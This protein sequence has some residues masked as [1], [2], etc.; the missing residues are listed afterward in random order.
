[1]IPIVFINCRKHPFLRKIMDLSKLYETRTRN[2]LGK[3]IGQR[4]LLCET[5]TGMNL[6]RCSAVIESIVSVRSRKD[7]EVY[8]EAACIPAGSDYDW[9]TDTKVKWLYKLTDVQPVQIPFTPPEDVRHGR[10]WMEFHPD[11]C[12]GHLKECL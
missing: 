4:V 9:T 11:S 7:W 5:G 12:P 3:L 8:R 1:M 6:V 2:M 10:T